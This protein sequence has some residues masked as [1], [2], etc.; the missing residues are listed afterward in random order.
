M[1]RQYHFR[2]AVLHVDA[3]GLIIKNRRCSHFQSIFYQLFIVSRAL[4][5]N[6]SSTK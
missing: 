2:L 6:N 5:I 4:F 1:H 3:E